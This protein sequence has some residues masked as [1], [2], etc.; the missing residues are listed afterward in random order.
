MKIQ[1]NVA[2]A[3]SSGE[4]ITTAVQPNGAARSVTWREGRT[5]SIRSKFSF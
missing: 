3:L 4:I 1:L 2:N 5:W